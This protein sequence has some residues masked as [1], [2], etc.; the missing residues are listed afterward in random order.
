MQQISRTKQFFYLLFGG[1]LSQLS[2]LI[3][4]IILAR[5]LLIEDYGT[6]RQIILVSGLIVPM[7]SSALP[8]SL[9]F[10]LPRLKTEDEK[11]ALVRRTILILSCLGILTG[12]AMIVFSG[13]IARQF[14]NPVLQRYLI[15]SSLYPA[16]ILGSS[17]FVPF[18]IAIGQAKLS[19]IYSSL[20]AFF[21]LIAVSASAI[22]IGTMDSIVVAIVLS[23]FFSF[24]IALYIS[25]NHLKIF[26]HKGIQTVSIKEQIS[27]AIPLGLAS[28]VSIWGLRLDQAIVSSYFDVSTYAIYTVGAMELPIVGI[29]SSSIYSILL[30]E[31]SRLMEEGRKDE[32]LKLWQRTIEKAMLVIMP[33]FGAAMIMSYPLITTIYT[34]RYEA[35]VPIFQIY[36]FLIPVRTI[37]FGL[38]LRAAGKTK[39][40]FYGSILFIV[41]NFAFA[42][43]TINILG[44]YGPTFSI[45]F[46]IYILICYLLLMIKKEI[47]FRIKDIL[48]LKSF[49]PIILIT[50]TPIALITIINS[51]ISLMSNINAIIVL[52]GYLLLVYI[53]Y[54]KTG[55]LSKIDNRIVKWLN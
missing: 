28:V 30:P 55:Q 18:M 15:L 8:N 40:D 26:S 39:Y 34:N 50:M 7:F 51:S 46:A 33:I 32:V 6:Y 48:N 17:Y 22:V 41:I 23:S 36:L 5:Q 24:I 12:I 45:V 9:L 13:L 38:L 31:I 43:S 35:S 3:L 16:F 1:G 54:K 29:I 10:F 25:N 2:S 14:N 4:I 27:Y 42:I 21:T 19:A 44:I 20:V 53:L 49:I 52:F 37:S 11:V 47:G